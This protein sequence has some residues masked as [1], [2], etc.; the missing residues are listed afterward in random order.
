MRKLHRWKIA[1][2][3]LLAI[4][5]IAA[6]LEQGKALYKQQNYAEAVSELQPLVDDA[7][8]HRE[9]RYYLALSLIKL[10]RLDEATAQLDAITQA[11]EG[12]PSEADL[13]TARAEIPLAR[14]QYPEAAALLTEAISM[15]PD[16]IQARM[17][18]AE[19]GLH[20]NNYQ[21]VA[22]DAEKVIALDPNN[23]YAYYYAGIA[24]SNLKRP[25]KMADYFQ[26]FLKMAPNAPEAAKVESL[27]RSLRR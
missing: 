1:G 14:K 12:T 11:G 4:P 27:L 13:K 23:A 6:D 8:D 24:Y 21:P 10:D 16:H 26:N 7:A 20:Q 9:A 25:D 3:L 15:N 5:V 19:V 22:E 2:A 18:R 17:L